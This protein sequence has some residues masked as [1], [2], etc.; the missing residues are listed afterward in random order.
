[1]VPMTHAVLQLYLSC[2]SVILSLLQLSVAKLYLK[3]LSDISVFISL[4]IS[5]LLLF[6]LLFSHLFLSFSLT[7]FSPFLSPLSLLFFHL[8]L[9]F[10]HH[11]FLSFSLTTFSPF[12]S[13]LSLLSSSPFYR[14]S[15]S[16]T[17]SKSDINVTDTPPPSN[18][19]VRF[20]FINFWQ[21]HTRTD[22]NIC[23]V[24]DSFRVHVLHTFY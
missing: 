22:S 13:P 16:F 15:L 4:S 9:S 10:R 6:S 19:S 5:N 7:S 1:M 3:G 18:D 24:I 12:L 17:Y 8:F 11:L 2:I 20:R 21:S 23:H 14:S